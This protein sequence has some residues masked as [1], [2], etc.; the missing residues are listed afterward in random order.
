MG[1]EYFYIVFL[2]MVIS[3]TLSLTFFM[4]WRNFG[5]KPHALT[6][7]VAFLAG[8]L[9]WLCSLYVDLFP[10]IKAYLLVENAFSMALVTLG[11]RGHCQRTRCRFLPNNL[12]PYALSVYAI[13]AWH[14]IVTPHVGI[15]MTVVPAYAAVTMLLSAYIVLAYRE[16]TRP[17]EWVVAIGLGVF[18]ITQVGAATLAF[19][20]G[21]TGYESMAAAYRHFNFLTLP[22]GYVAVSTFII[23]MMASDISAK[24]KKMAVQ[25]QLTGL[26]NRRGFEEY[27]GRAFSAARRA[28]QSISVIMTDI[29]RFKHIND[30]FGHA[31]GDMA[32]AHFARLFSE[33]RRQEDVAARVGGEE[34]ALLLPGT[35]LRGAMAIADQLCA[36]IG[37]TPL[38]TTVVGLPMTSSF[39]VAAIS[40]KDKSLDDV[41]LRADRALYRSKRAGRNQVDLESSQL[42]RAADGKLIPV[43][44]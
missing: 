39:G 30:K 13:I 31:A 36:K 23:L 12:W 1:S 35:D 20:Q 9:Q 6:W 34:F 21:A 26:L 40:E 3:A 43:S 32:L 29:D 11:L 14:I 25:D 22:A 7:S 44:S 42:L 18:A 16:R 24:L 2:L 8:S 28:G 17:A 27:G 10:S 38:D 19:M 4:A 15:R 33:S 5:R 41:L 37:S